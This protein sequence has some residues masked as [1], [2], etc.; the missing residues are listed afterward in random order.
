VSLCDV[1]P[2]PIELWGCVLSGW[3]VG[4]STGE[5]LFT[6]DARGSS[7]TL[8]GLLLSS[9]EALHSTYFMELISIGGRR[10]FPLSP[11][12]LHSSFAGVPGASM[13]VPAHDKGHVE[14]PDMQRRVRTRGPPLDLP[15][16]LP[17]NRNLSVLLF[18]DFHQLL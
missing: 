11:L 5:V 4:A 12:G 8:V 6:F 3:G 1:Q 10:V 15:E 9:C 17:Q 14:R 16:H 18:Y 7:L 2:T 13:G